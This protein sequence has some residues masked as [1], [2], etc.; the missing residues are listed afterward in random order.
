MATKINSVFEQL[1]DVFCNTV[2]KYDLVP[3]DKHK[4]VIF[5]SG[6]KDAS[7]ATDLFMEYKNKVRPDITIELLTV[8][9]PEMIYSSSDPTQ[10]QFVKDAIKYWEDKGC[11][12]KWVNLPAGIG[13]HLFDN[14]DVPCQVCES[15]KV[16]IIYDELTKEEY[17]DSL[18]C[19][20]HTVEDIS[21]Y[22]S[23]IFY[24]GASS[25]D[26]KEMRQE[27]PV[28]FSRTMELAK[29]VYPK[30][31]PPAFKTNITYIKPLIEMEEDVIKAV[32]AERQYPD[33]PECCAKIRGSKFKMYKRIVMEC[34]DWLRDRYQNE[35]EV[36]SNMVF[37]NYGKMLKRYQDTGLIPTQK[38]IESF[39]LK[40]G[41]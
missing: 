33:I 13:D 34:F 36:S 30:Y 23:E 8:K 1:F 14:E 19:L 37:K 21:G 41:I 6:G 27:N 18:V 11:T 32:K 9:F 16:K 5:Y 38:E 20:A 4:V 3:A 24:I 10:K 29:R 22:F 25:K 39:N 12:H 26:W 15:V 2:K 17:R 28:L 31:Q 35:K 7:L 40:S